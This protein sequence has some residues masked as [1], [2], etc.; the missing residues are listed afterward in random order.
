MIQKKSCA[1]SLL[2]AAVFCV[3]VCSALL[4]GKGVFHN[5]SLALS[6][7]DVVSFGHVALAPG[8]P[9]ID[10]NI[11]YPVLTGLFIRLMG[12]LGSSQAGYYLFTS[13]ALIALAALTTY[14]LYVMAKE[15]EREKLLLYWALAP[16]MLVF[17]VYN[18]DMLALFLVVSGFYLLRAKRRVGAIALFALAA[19]AKFYPLLYVA[20]LLMQGRKTGQWL[21]DAAV[22]TGTLLTVNLYFIVR[23][24]RGWSYFLAFNSARGPN[25]DSIWSLLRAYLWP[26]LTTSDINTISFALF[27][28]SAAFALWRFRDS[29]PIHVAFLLTLLF[30]FCNKVFSPQYALWLLPFYILSY[31]P[32][33]RLFYL[34]ELVNAGVLFTILPIFFAPEQAILISLNPLLVIVRQILVAFLIAQLVVRLI[35]SMPERALAQSAVSG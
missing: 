16:S 4:H 9:Y 18:W 7:S 31:A 12:V 17:T 13:F 28:L 10:T 35:H 15:A 3:G 20:P 34:F 27:G 25:P 1:L 5:L 30:L 21:Y 29:E 2:L 24:F 19:S 23:N 14:F 6:Y 33:R 32:Q 8:V 22:F 26:H 11:E